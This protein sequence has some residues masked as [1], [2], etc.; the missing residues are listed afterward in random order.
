MVALQVYD[1]FLDIYIYDFNCIYTRFNIW[2]Y[3]RSFRNRK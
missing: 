3:L 2:K 1:N